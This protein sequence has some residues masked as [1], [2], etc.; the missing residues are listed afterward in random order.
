[1]KNFAYA[2]IAIV[3]ALFAV[4]LP[5]AHAQGPSSGTYKTYIGEQPLGTESYTLTVQPDGTRR[6]ESEMALGPSKAK[7]VTVVSGNR[8]VSFTLE[9]GGVMAVSTQFGGASAK[10]TVP[11]KEAREVPTQ[12]GVVM[13]NLVW[14]Q[15]IFLLAQYD[16]ARG[17]QQSFKVL[18]PSQ[19]TEYTLQVERVGT[20]VY[21][22]KNAKVATEQYR[23]VTSANLLLEVWTDA[24]RTPLLLRV[25]AQSIKVVRE[26]SE[27]LS[28]VVFAAPPTVKSSAVE[29]FTSEEVSFS[30]GDVKLAG[31]LTVPKSAGAPV[32]AAVIITGSG[33]Q[34]RDGSNGVLN[35]YKLIAERL[36][37]NGVA[38]L[39]ADDRG[40]GKSAMPQSMKISYRDLIGD[41]RAA[42][43]Y[44]WTRPEIDKTRIALV[45]HSE[46]AETAMIIASEDA[47]VAA[48]ALLAGA[49]RPLDR[50]A[51]EQ[52]LYAVALH[53]PLNLSDLMKLNPLSRDIMR[54][55]DEAKAEPKPGAPENGMRAYLLE[56]AASDPSAIARRV[57]CPVLIL[58]G[59][60][61]VNVL[62]YHALELGQALSQSGNKRVTVRIFPNLTHLFTP[63]TF[64][65]AVTGDKSSEVSADFLQTLQSWATEVLRAANKE[66]GAKP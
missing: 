23:I 2:V 34:D 64:D 8:P 15:F 4:G 41:S 52:A 14:H 50:V 61:D 16:A 47:R 31:T 18:L 59:E 12:A 29:P 55:F 66:G 9:L 40:V 48:V 25:P 58:N 45:G 37:A 65:A 26:G 7:A 24:A 3:V 49:S 54:M 53:E 63:S 44:L 60:R 57:R 43:D 21:S 38:V 27:E 1:M 39:R 35:L 19:A 20:P 51:F 11:G 10:I 36:S 6:A 17:G 13:E 32:P 56:H 42:F 62:P 5:T 30:N 28:Q 46:G 22:V 33:G